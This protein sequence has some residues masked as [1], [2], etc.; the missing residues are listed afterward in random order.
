MAPERGHMAA[1]AAEKRQHV[2]LSARQ[3]NVQAWWGHLSKSASHPVTPYGGLP[4]ECPKG[5]CCVSAGPCAGVTETF[6][7]DQRITTHNIE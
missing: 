4:V 1:D 5:E 3:V 7:L 6:T 2:A